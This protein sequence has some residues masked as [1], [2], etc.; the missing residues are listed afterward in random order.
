MKRKTVF[1]VLLTAILSCVIA[2]ISA[3]T[4]SGPVAGESGTTMHGVV[5]AFEAVEA[6]G[7]TKTASI[8]GDKYIVTVIGESG[9]TEYTVDADYNIDS[10]KD[11][12]GADR[13]PVTGKSAFERVYEAALA[14]SGIEPANV[15][16]FDFD[17]D[18]YMGMNV[19]KVEIE[20]IGAKYKLIYRADDMSIVSRE[21]E[22][23]NNIPSG[24]YI[25]E[26]AAKDIAVNAVAGADSGATGFVVKASFE[27]G[28][29]I[30][31]VS[32]D[33]GNYRY[34]IGVDAVEGSVV[35]VSKSVSGSADMPG[36]DENITA[37]EA[38]EIAL[39][40]VFGGNTPAGYAFRQ[41]KPD[42][43]DGR[44]VYEIELVVEG[45]EYE[46][47]IAASSGDILDVDIE[48]DGYRGENLPE[49]KRFIQ[50]ADAIAAVRAAAGA[51]IYV[52]EI[53]IEYDKTAKKYYYE[54]DIIS[55][56]VEQEYLVDALTGMATLR[57]G[58]KAETVV[59][60][61][62]AY[63]SALGYFKAN[64]GLEEAEITNRVVKLERDDGRYYF[65]V[66]IFVGQTE[67]KAEID[68][69]TGNVYDVEIER[70]ENVIP[71][72]ETFITEQRAKELAI[73]AA[74]GNATVVDVDFEY[75][76]GRYF[77]EVEVLVNGVKRDYYVDA[78]T[79]AV[80][81]NEN[82]VDGGSQTITRD[83]ALEIAY[84]YFGIEDA[85]AAEVHKVKLERDDGRLCF[86]IEFYIGRIEY[87]IEI[88]AQTGAV[89]DAEYS[90]D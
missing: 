9:L 8:S 68:A 11:I 31:R 88:D 1:A 65:E 51:D 59:T 71:P 76:N 72:S 57:E 32:F 69:A 54:V 53:E 38:K 80:S 48:N 10:Q 4:N 30:Y 86:E 77:Y 2:A 67:Y 6:D 43:E 33:Y 90:Y 45:T 83:E 74:G 16:G 28:R 34:E 3:C 39:K 22:F 25:T 63:T 5:K 24:T 21:I 61:E 29:K 40:F 18:T 73:E 17:T 81:Q 50:R 41:V 85:G 44:L 78:A 70:N 15:T 47:E 87:E 56:G 89:I 7:I 36:G 82:F 75:G 19:Y 12:L 46:F 64:H 66:K 79:G 13:P 20:E 14:E 42:Y 84:G 35:R 26:S 27:S 62:D 55:G 58:Y 37:D 23:E 60:E 49:N 52:V